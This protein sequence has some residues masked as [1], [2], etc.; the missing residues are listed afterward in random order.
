MR[1]NLAY[2]YNLAGMHEEAAS[3]Y[4][5]V[6]KAAPNHLN[7][8]ANYANTLNLLGRHADALKATTRLSV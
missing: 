1:Y 4:E 6:L 8:H 3:R 2:A 5:K 7:A